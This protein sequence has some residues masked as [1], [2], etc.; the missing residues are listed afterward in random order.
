MKERYFRVLN[1]SM[2]VDSPG[3]SCL[4][5]DHVRAHGGWLSTNDVSTAIFIM[6]VEAWMACFCGLTFMI[7]CCLSICYLQYVTIQAGT[8]NGNEH[9]CCRGE[10]GKKRRNKLYGSV[11]LRWTA[12]EVTGLKWPAKLCQTQARDGRWLDNPA[13]WVQEGF[14]SETPASAKVS[15]RFTQFHTSHKVTA[16]LPK[17]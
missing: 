11:G 3:I 16:L 10:D 7:N 1:I 15:L 4:C 2:D 8:G 5:W 12:R 6:N 14:Q 13:Q 9:H 17:Y